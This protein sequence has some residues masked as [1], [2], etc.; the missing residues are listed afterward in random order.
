M[1]LN[2]MFILAFAGSFF[3]INMSAATFTYS[4]DPLN[5]ITNAAYSDGSRESYSYDP[6]GNRGSR[7]TLAATRQLDTIPP[8]IPTNLVSTAFIPSQLSIA[9]N[10]SFDT[11]GSGL[12]G[13]YIYVNGSWIATTTGTN[14]SLSGLSPSTQYCLTI[15][16]FDHDGNISTQ[17][18][19]LCFSTPLFQPPYLTSLGFSNGNFQIGVIGGTAGPYDVWGSSNLFSWQKET[20]VTLP[21]ANGNFL[22]LNLRSNKQYFYRLGWRTNAP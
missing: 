8:S 22:P 3:L 16:A 18:M 19:S 5:R 6:A 11:G 12:A 2:K 20:N 15:A 21:L 4:Y 1:N 10:R 7:V 17:S 9:W 13:Y 14:F